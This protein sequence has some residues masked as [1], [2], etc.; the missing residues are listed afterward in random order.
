M[1]ATDA[2]KTFG[3]LVDR[4]RETRVTYVIERSGRPVALISPVENQ[5][6]TMADF[7]RLMT[8]LPRGERAHADAVDRV[9]ARRNRP[10]VRRNPWAR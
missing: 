1:S 4:V 9:S 2:A 3:S 7:R 8:S 5:A 10:H 6:F